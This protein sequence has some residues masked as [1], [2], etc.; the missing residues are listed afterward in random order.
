[1]LFQFST[2]YAADCMTVFLKIKAMKT[3]VL[4]QLTFLTVIMLYRFNK[5]R[6]S[7]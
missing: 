6:T 7:I 1:M 5:N 3:D 2:I 4:F